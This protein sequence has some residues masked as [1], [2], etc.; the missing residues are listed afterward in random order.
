MRFVLVCKK[1]CILTDDYNENEIAN[2]L[3]IRHFKEDLKKW[4][5]VGSANVLDD[6]GRF[7]CKVWN[8]RRD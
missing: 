7:I 8:K 4:N 2:K 6:T 5:Y 1:G 3:H